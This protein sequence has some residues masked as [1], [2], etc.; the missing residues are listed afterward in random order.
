MQDIQGEQTSTAADANK[1]VV[2]FLD[3]TL[4]EYRAISTIS[5][6]KQYNQLYPP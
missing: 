4:T 1:R 3:V 2:D 5:K 6:T